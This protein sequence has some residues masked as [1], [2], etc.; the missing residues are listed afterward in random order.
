MQSGVAHGL[1]MQ[2]NIDKTTMKEITTI[3]ILPKS[4]ASNEKNAR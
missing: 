3:N 4:I 1:L 2:S